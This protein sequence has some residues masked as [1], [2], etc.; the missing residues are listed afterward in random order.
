[1][2]EL[3]RRADA[4]GQVIAEAQPAAPNVSIISREVSD[5]N[6]FDFSEVY[7]PNITGR[8]SYPV[9]QLGP[10]L[11]GAAKAIADAVQS[12]LET[13]AHSILTVAAFTAHSLAN[14]VIDVRTIPLSLFVLTISESGERKSSSDKLAAS[15]LEAHQK[16]LLEAYP[17]LL[18]DHKDAEAIYKKNYGEA[19]KGDNPAGDLAQLVEPLPPPTPIILAQE[20]TLEGLQKSFISGLPSQALFTD[21]GGQF[22]GGHAM[23]ADNMLKTIAG[24]SKFWDGSPIIRTRA[25]DGESA[26]LYGRRLSI[27]LMVQ[28]AVVEKHMS[29]PLLMQQGWLARFLMVRST[30]KAGTRKYNAGATLDEA[31]QGFHT[32]IADLLGTAVID[33]DGS[34]KLSELGLE[35]GANEVY[36]EFYDQVEIEQAVGGEFESIRPVA[37]KSGEMA[38]RLAGIFSVVELGDSVT[39]EQM[40]R[41]CYLAMYY[42]R[43]TLRDNQ[44][45]EANNLDRLALEYLE[46]M[47]GQPGS[48]VEIDFIQRM[49]PRREHRQKVPNIRIVMERLVRAGK[50]ECTGTNTKGAANRWKRI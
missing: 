26:A 45:A 19:L 4:Y 9:E 13:A 43:T 27:H 3:D 46:W 41:G 2:S 40:L 20:P 31:L 30:P 18:K 44:I 21:E 24:L 1:M 25:G 39:E 11:G 47:A 8:Q 32:R 15:G 6:S 36:A 38:L 14:V 48:E 17:E 22:L 10:L 5:T 28:P 7:F 12:P 50:V 33:E 16:K 34:C 42:L 49:A 23:N 29:D 35:P 37:S